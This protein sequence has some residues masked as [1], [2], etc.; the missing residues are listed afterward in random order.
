MKTNIMNR[1]NELN[2]KS[3]LSID[4]ETNGLWGQAFAISALLFD[5]EGN[6]SKQ[7]IGRCPIEEKVNPWVEENCL[8]KMEDIKENYNDY[9]TMLKA[10]FDFLQE[11]KDEV[12]LTHMGHIVESKLLHDAHQMGIIGDWDAPYLWYD[13]CLF[14]DDS[15]DKYCQE[16]NINIGESNTHNPIY[17]CLSAYKAFKYFVNAQN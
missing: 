16:N 1:I 7:F 8:P 9:K 12:V 2:T 11:N 17:D 5:A 3:I 6:P 13:V 10:F 15:T 4:A 14:F